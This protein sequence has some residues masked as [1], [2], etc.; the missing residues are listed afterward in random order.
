[1]LHSQGEGADAWTPEV[2]AWQQDFLPKRAVWEGG[3]ESD[4]TVDSHCLS[5]VI[6][7][8]INRHKSCS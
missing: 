3:G 5:Q 6:K 7:V 1:M 2:L 8:N 4:F